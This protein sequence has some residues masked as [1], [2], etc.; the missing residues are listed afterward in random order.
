MGAFESTINVVLQRSFFVEQK[1]WG[2]WIDEMEPV[3]RALTKQS[4]TD[5][6][7]GFIMLSYHRCRLQ[8]VESFGQFGCGSGAS[9]A[10]CLRPLDSGDGP[11]SEACQMIAGFRAQPDS[12]R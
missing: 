3:G 2:R 11:A 4:S 8:R 6:A 7:L 12:E 1:E 9:E 5:G 10:H